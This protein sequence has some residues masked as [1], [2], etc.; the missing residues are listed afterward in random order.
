MELLGSLA[1]LET[2]DLVEYACLPSRQAQRAGVMLRGSVILQLEAPTRPEALLFDLAELREWLSMFVADDFVTSAAQGTDRPVEFCRYVLETFANEAN[3]YGPLLA[4]RIRPGMRV[5]E[6]G[7]GLGFLS[8]WLARQGIDVT[9]LEPASGPFDLFAILSKAIAE[10]AGDPR[11]KVLPIRAEELSRS[12]HGQF[13][14]IY[15]FHVLEH[16]DDLD[17]AYAA[18][19]EALAPG[20]IMLHC[21]PNYTFP[22]DPHLGIPLVP[23]APH[24]TERLFRKRIAAQRQVWDS[25]NFITARR[26]RD[27]AG[28]HQLDHHLLPGQMYATI[29]R[30]EN[31]PIFTARHFGDATARWVRLVLKL[32]RAVGLLRLFRLVPASVLS[33]MTAIIRKPQAF[34]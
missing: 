28:R 26:L 33:P 34:F 9:P 32:A 20:G 17:G 14:F 1:V 18:M 13:D 6:V 8:L 4:E 12:K 5:L 24:A 16:V 25:L 31:D 22:Y 23:G 2:A 15:S 3:I 30:L 7:S 19:A 27:L 29:E 21:C 11:P 10:R